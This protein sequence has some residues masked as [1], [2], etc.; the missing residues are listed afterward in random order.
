MPEPRVWLDR[1]QDEIRKAEEFGSPR[2]LWH[3][4]RAVGNLVAYLR[5]KEAE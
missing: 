3:L 2:A 1:C 5:A 4:V